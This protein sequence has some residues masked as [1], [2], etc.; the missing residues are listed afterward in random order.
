VYEYDISKTIRH[1]AASRQGNIWGSEAMIL[2]IFDEDISIIVL[3]NS[4][5]DAGMW[6]LIWTMKRVIYNK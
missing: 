1:K 3:S 5:G 4:I 6:D 2:K